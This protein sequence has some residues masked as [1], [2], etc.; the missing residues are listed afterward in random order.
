MTD[1]RRNDT[2]SRGHI[3]ATLREEIA[4]D[5]RMPT[6]QLD[7]D[8]S[9]LKLGMDSMRLM[10]WMHRLRKRGHKVKLRDLYQQ[11]TVRGWSQL[12]Q[13]CPAT[14]PAA[15][16]ASPQP[17]GAAS[18]AAVAWPTMADGH[19][20][21]LTPV[22]HA[23]L[24]GRAPHQTLGGVGCHLYQE[25]DGQGLDADALEQAI[26]VLVERHPML[27]VTFLDDGR[28][29]RRPG[30][31]WRGL[32]LHDLRSASPAQCEAHLLAMRARHGHRILDVGQGENFDFQLSL[33]PDG[34]HRLHA[35]IDL[36][37]L[38]S[39]WCSMNWRRWFAANACR[40]S[41]ATTIFAAIWPRRRR[42]TRRPASRPRRSGW[43]ARAVCRT[44]R[45]CRWPASRSRSSRFA[46]RA[47]E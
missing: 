35:D 19:P 4:A 28:Q 11:P 39:A 40:R 32:T 31:R 18:P 47:S 33:L 6:G 24:V 5:L 45:S 29:Q 34:H 13:D 20:F 30:T 37:A 2:P 21:E 3:E 36:L 23:Y 44:H 7:A 14:A 26:G 12:L 8:A 41:R 17:S 42:R 10:A 25:F 9:L 22:Q 1:A 16:A 27:T 43:S 46:S 38:V 15:Q